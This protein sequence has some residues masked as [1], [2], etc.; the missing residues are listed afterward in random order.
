MCLHRVA[1]PETWEGERGRGCLLLARIG[2]KF[3]LPPPPSS[4]LLMMKMKVV[5]IV[6][7]LHAGLCVKYF[8]FALSHSDTQQFYERVVLIYPILE[9]R[10]LGLTLV[11]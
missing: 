11:K 5:F 1:Q 7:L 10:K 8:L 4:S 6:G 9:I 2:S 3:T